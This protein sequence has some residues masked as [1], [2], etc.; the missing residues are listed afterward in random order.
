M[1]S[2]FQLLYIY[3][4]LLCVISG[5]VLEDTNN[6][7]TL[8][9]GFPATLPVSKK[10]RLTVSLKLLDNVFSY[11]LTDKSSSQYKALKSKVVEAVS[12]AF[13]LLLNIFFVLISFK[14]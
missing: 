8:M 14:L 2:Y 3:L 11:D 4:S 12:D 9:P 1:V 13:N 10:T 6:L 7:A 5:T